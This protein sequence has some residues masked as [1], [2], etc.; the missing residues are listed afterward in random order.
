[1]AQAAPSLA[2]VKDTHE[3]VAMSAGQDARG[4]REARPASVV[5]EVVEPVLK[6]EV[7]KGLI[8]AEE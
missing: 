1:M 8:E 7:R 5:E 3:R 6:R 4:G 2:A